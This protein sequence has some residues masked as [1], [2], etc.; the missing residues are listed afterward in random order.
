MGAPVGRRGRDDDELP[1]GTA[2]PP[3]RQRKKVSHGGGSLETEVQGG[4]ARAGSG[5]SSAMTPVR[6][7]LADVALILALALLDPA[8]APWTQRRLADADN[9]SLLSIKLINFKS[10]QHFAVDF[11]PR[12]NF[13]VGRNGTGK[14]SIL[15][16]I[17]AAL[18]GNPNKHSSTAGGNRAGHGLVRDG[19]EAASVEVRKK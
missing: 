1:E 2:P 14:S 15:A 7:W 5:S 11:G 19:A 12:V 17:I 8:R 9:G 18:G 4:N 13:I 3:A 6:C 16:G 10:H